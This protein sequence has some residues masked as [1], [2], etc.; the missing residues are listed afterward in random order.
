MAQHHLDE[1]FQCRSFCCCAYPMVQHHL[2]D[3]LTG[4]PLFLPFLR[5]LKLL[6]TAMRG[7][8]NIEIEHHHV[9][10]LLFFAFL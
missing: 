7:T 1:R 4:Q 8:R 5:R 6:N 10:S 3:L 9:F 2:D